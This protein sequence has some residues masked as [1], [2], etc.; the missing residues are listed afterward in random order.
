LE[1]LQLKD[2]TCNW[3]NLNSERKKL[4]NLALSITDRYREV[5]ATNG[6]STH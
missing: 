2:A 4:E 5:L 3:N 1:Y 6:G